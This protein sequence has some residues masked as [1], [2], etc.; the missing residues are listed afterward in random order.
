MAMRWIMVWMG[1]LVAGHGQ[2][3]L[4]SDFDGSQTLQC[5]TAQGVQYHYSGTHQPFHP[6]SVG[7]PETFIIDFRQGLIRPTRQSVIR[8]RSTIKRTERV[9]DML[10]L[11]GAE[12]GVE[13]VDDGVGWTLALKKNGRIVVTAS[14][15]DMGYIVFGRCRAA[16]R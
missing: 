16:A 7:L 12:D 4:A 8:K 3:A 6:E 9:E 5:F 11:Q 1:I 2:T 15:G 13:G 14:G 10:V